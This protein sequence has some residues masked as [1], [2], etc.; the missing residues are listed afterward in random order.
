MIF[1]L[2]SSLV[3]GTLAGY[4]HYKKANGGTDDHQ[5][6]VKIARNCGL[7]NA[8]GKEIRIYRRTKK[9]SH[10]EFVYQMPQGLS[11]KQFVQK[12]DNFQD[13]LNIKK[14]M[15][16]ISLKDFKLINWNKNVLNQIRVIL[17]Q[18]RKVRK[19]VE[20]SFDG[21]LVFKIYDKPLTDQFLYDEELLKL[22]K[23][24][25]VPIG[26]S[27]TGELIFNDFDEIYNL[28]V[29]G[30]PGYGKSVM[31][32]NI[33]TTLVANKTKDVKLCLVDLKGGLSFNRFKI[34]EQVETVAK[35]PKEALEAL[36][37]VQDR[38]NNTIEYLLQHGY[39]D[40]KEAGIKE[41]HFT[42]IDEAA[43]L[44]D[45]KD[46]VEIVKDIS[47]RGRGAGFRLVYCTQYATNEVLPSQVRQNC[48]ARLCFKLQTG[49]ASRAVLDEEGAE[50]L[51]L[52]RGRAIYRTVEKQIVQTPFISN[53]FI[54]ET[55]KPN[56]TF[57]ARGERK[58]VNEEGN[59][60][61]T[62]RR[63]H[64]LLIEETELS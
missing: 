63:S 47:R 35:N 6:I 7:V 60:T 28:I 8:E 38:M 22:C 17:I 26:L 49:T 57:K 37:D 4:A 55:I 52:I 13:G 2:T 18:T 61:S 58:E 27:K 5:K 42:I 48:D 12:L 30:S 50:S 54:D 51:P 31:L 20:I 24:W 39:E 1:E 53:S 29:A 41:R 56:I 59:R 32:K 44:F 11:S 16:D 14:S 19:E 45:E 33:I 46:A 23:G 25:K 34:L 36:R 3:A 62:E 21:M 43:D 40:V 10:T 64:T 9:Q 15:P